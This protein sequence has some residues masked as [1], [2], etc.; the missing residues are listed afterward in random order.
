MKVATLNPAAVRPP[1]RLQ[2]PEVKLRAVLDLAPKQLVLRTLRRRLRL[3]PGF[4]RVRTSRLAQGFK[5]DLT[6][7]HV[8][9]MVDH[10]HSSGPGLPPPPS[11]PSFE[12]RI[13]LPPGRVVQIPFLADLSGTKT[14]DA[15]IF[16]LVQTSTHDVVEGGLTLA[17]V[18]V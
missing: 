5:F 6:G 11:P 1:N 15:C 17:M 16:H 18:R 7:F 4:R 10:S 8:S 3:V 12:A 13:E 14:G 2:K 9:G